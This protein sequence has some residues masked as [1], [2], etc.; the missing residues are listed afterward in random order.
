MWYICVYDVWCVCVVYAYMCVDACVYGMFILAV[1][2]MHRL[3][4]VCACVRKVCVAYGE[5][6][7]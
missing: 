6:D 7:V 1:C 2:M 3:C 4:G 5:C